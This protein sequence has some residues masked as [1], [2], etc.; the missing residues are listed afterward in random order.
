[1]A[2]GGALIPTADPRVLAPLAQH[3]H[4]EGGISAQS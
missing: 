2:K 4:Q 1:M 3:G